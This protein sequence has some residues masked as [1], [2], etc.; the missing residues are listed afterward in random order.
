MPPAFRAAT[1]PLTAGEDDFSPAAA[2]PAY[3]SKKEM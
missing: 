1:V 3:G 2:E